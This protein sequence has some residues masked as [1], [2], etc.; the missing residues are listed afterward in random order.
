M[1]VISVTVITIISVKK[2]MVMVRSVTKQYQKELAN[3]SL[4]SSVWLLV[5]YSM[6]TGLTVEIGFSIPLTLS[7][8]VEESCFSSIPESVFDPSYLFIM[9]NSLFCI[10]Y[11]FSGW[12][13]D[14][15]LGRKKALSLSLWLCWFGTLLQCV[16][17]CIQYGTCGLPVN[18]A[19][20]GISGVA[21]V[22]IIIGNAGLFTNIPALGI[23]Q[24]FDMPHTHSQAFLYWTVWGLFL[25]FIV[26]YIGFVPNSI[27]S[28]DLTQITV[29][30][31]FALCSLAIC[32]HISFHRCFNTVCKMYKNP[33]KLVFNVLRYTWHHKVPE[34]R[35]AF[36]Y[37]DDNK[38][39]RIDFGVHKYGGPFSIEEVEDVKAFLSILLIF[40]CT[41]G[42]FV[43][44]YHIL[45][46]VFSYINVFHDASTSVNGYG[47]FIL[48]KLCDSSILIIVPLL[49]VLVIPLFPKVEYFI[50]NSLRGMIICYFFTMVAL[51]FLILL[52]SLEYLAALKGY[53]SFEYFVFP[54]MFSGFVGSF[55]LVFGLAFI[56]SQAPQSMR[57]MLTGLYW[58]IRV[59]FSDVGV[60]FSLLPFHSRSSTSLWTLVI[61]L[62]IALMGLICFTVAIRWYKGKKRS[63]DYD[64]HWNIENIY[65]N[66]VGQVNK[67]N[68]A[69]NETYAIID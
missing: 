69:G 37:C 52:E 50:S 20:Y 9:K 39:S 43:P 18:I 2:V 36:T 61:L 40:A 48:W 66:S 7:T 17:Y 30:A 58:F 29:L 1:W 55:S 14:I 16:S 15:V 60:L 63:D 62:L 19:K 23:D 33:Y 67:D 56:F 51:I 5:F 46:G 6:I 47:A 12:F 22:F 44:Y 13:S 49:Y 28:P 26:G 64:V 25:G 68:N 3:H 53:V 24:L 57:G 59:S 32:L 41:F 21:F 38:I 45:I 34:Q 65:N 27:Y 54:L 8:G 4:N 10:L 11:P 35:S 31:I 42:I